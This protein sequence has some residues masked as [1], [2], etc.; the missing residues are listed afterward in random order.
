MQI[1][2]TGPE[3]SGK[4][5]LFNTLAAELNIPAVPELTVPYLRL[6]NGKYNVNDLVQLCLLQNQV[7]QTLAAIGH[8][9]ILFDTSYLVLKVWSW[10][11]YRM[12]PP[13]IEY[14]FRKE[15]KTHYLL[16]QPLQT[17]RPDLLRE[18]PLDRWALYHLYLKNL[19]LQGKSYSILRGTQAERLNT[20]INT[21]PWPTTQA[22][23]QPGF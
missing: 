11:R 13:D 4:T 14:A 7:R 23:I 9:T 10:Y 1:V 2:I 3:C 16:C 6:R 21:I 12:V 8:N 19:W 17:Y 18:N 15:D 5:T 20:A 22:P